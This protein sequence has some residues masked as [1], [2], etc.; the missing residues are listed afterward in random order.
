MQS[1]EDARPPDRPQG[2]GLQVVALILAALVPVA[3]LVGRR[4]VPPAQPAPLAL[5][6][7]GPI[8]VLQRGAEGLM[9]GPNPASLT[10]LPGPGGAYRLDFS[11]GGGD[12][13]ATPPYRLKILGPGGKEIWQGSWSGAADSRVEVVLPAEG[14][15]S[16]PHALVATDS[17]GRV[18]S[19]PFL[20][21]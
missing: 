14:L 19:F 17:V 1:P 18:R 6:A 10:A 20:V 8:V 16:G 2:L 12:K 15:S 7:S 13:N 4:T 5:D 11:P 21:P 3:W 9:A